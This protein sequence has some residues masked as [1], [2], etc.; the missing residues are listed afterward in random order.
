MKRIC[1]VHQNFTLGRAVS[2]QTSSHNVP[3]AVGGNT[4]R[5]FI[6]PSKLTRGQR[7]ELERRQSLLEQ[8]EAL[9]QKGLGKM[10]AAAEL[11]VSYTSLW[12]YRN[13][14]SA[15]GIE[16]LR[17]KTWKCS[18]RPTIFQKLNPPA[19]ILSLVRKLQ[20]GGLSNF[21]SWKKIAFDP[22]CPAA[23]SAY[24]KSRSSVSPTLLR[25]TK[26]IRR[27]ATVIQSPDFVVIKE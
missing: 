15:N 25:A 22:R 21:D 23:L 7:R 12:R 19:E 4:N 14:F 8:F 1:Q 10:E 2:W 17:P 16:G 3:A 13:S 26:L 9:I 24:L 5:P 11:D 18:G 6:S 27:K 20:L